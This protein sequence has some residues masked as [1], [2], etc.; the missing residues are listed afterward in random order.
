MP[1]ELA[2]RTAVLFAGSLLS[3]GFGGLVGAGVQ[4]GLDGVRGLYSW[5]WL[6]IIEGAITMALSLVSIFIF[7]DFPS[8]TRWLSEQEK[9][10][11]VHRL[12]EHSGT[13]DE[14]RGSILRG[15]AMAL[16]DYKVWLLAGVVILKTSAA[17]V[18]SF[19][20]TLVATFNLQQ[21]DFTP[22]SRSALSVCH[23]CVL[24]IP[25]LCPYPCLFTTA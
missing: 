17:A 20:P 24:A 11:A 22:A 14:E 6:F 3:G 4:Y 15:V 10:I 2:T 5:Q 8:N 19:I 12:R 21:G 18:T 25:S 16:T 1:K 9:T 23:N 13:L 7:P